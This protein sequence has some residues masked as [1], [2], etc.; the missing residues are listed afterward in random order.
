MAEIRLTRPAG[1]RVDSGREYQVVID[2]KRVGGIK[3]DE[4]KVYTVSSGRHELRLKQDWASSEKLWVDL[5][6]SDQAQF[7]CAPRIKQND[8]TMTVGFRVIYWATLGCKRYIDLRPGDEIAAVES[9]PKQWPL[10]LDGPKLFGIALLIGVAYWALTG[11][12]I[13]AVGV[14]VAAMALVVSALVGRGIGKAAVR[15]NKKVQEHRD[16]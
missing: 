6:D 9:E 2:R 4:S 16:G 13:V 5:G 12:S 15:A 7:V 14:V 8:E 1:Y 10:G 3:V 11:Q